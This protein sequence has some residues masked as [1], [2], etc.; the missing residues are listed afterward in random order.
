MEPTIPHMV[1]GVFS[2]RPLASI[3]AS[4]RRPWLKAFGPLECLA[5]ELS[6]NNNPIVCYEAA[7]DQTR[8]QRAAIA[9][10]TSGKMQ[11]VNTINPSA[12][13]IAGRN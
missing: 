8:K 4:S 11:P 12:V 6:A 3:I 2:L 1:M 7:F 5:Y 13:V 10:S 9:N